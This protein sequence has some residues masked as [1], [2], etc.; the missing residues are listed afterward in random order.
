MRKILVCASSAALAL[1]GIPALVAPASAAVTPHLNEIHYDNV[2]TDVGEAIEIA[3]DPNADLTGWRIVLYN[4]N[5]GASYDDDPVPNANAG[6]LRRRDLPGQRH[7]ERRPGRRGA[8][9]A[10]TARLPSSCPTSGTM[11]AIGGPGGRPDEHRHR[12]RRGGHPS[13]AGLSLQLVGSTWTGP[14]ASTFGAANEEIEEPPPAPPTGVCGDPATLI[15]QIQGS[16]TVF[17]PAFS[18]RQTVEGV[19]SAV[20]PGLNGFYLQEEADDT[21]AEAATSEGIF[22][23]TGSATPPSVTVGQT[24]RLAGDVAEFGSAGSITQLTEPVYL[25]C[26]VPAATVTATTVTFPLAAAGDMERYEGMLVTFEQDLVISEYFNY[27]R[28]GEVVAAVPPNGW[29]RLYTPTAVVEPGAEAI[30]LAELY[31]R[32]RIT[33]D[34]SSTAQNP[35]ALVHPGNGEPYSLENSFRGGDTVTGVTG[36]IDH[37]FGLYRVH[38][39]AYGEYTVENPRPAAPAVGGEIQVASFNVLNYFLNLTGDGDVCGPNQ[40]EECRGADTEEERLRQRAKI[41]AAIAALDADVV[42]LMEMENTTG[43][44]PAADLVAGLNELAGAGTYAYVDTGVVGTD[45]IRL[46]PALQARRRHPGR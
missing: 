33:I 29:A 16:G 7:P 14:L 15:H 41:V 44:E 45:V 35:A 4:G 34:D 21:D 18:G 3:A 36:V 43:A 19:V 28:F 24:L 37:S 22:V 26:S 42:G 20:K 10:R 11:T 17:D 31:A 2:G 32:S 6:R 27:A 23:Y 38:P 8:G 40:D 12:C 25:T 9:S 5:G 1:A 13:P 46:G 39:T 30:A